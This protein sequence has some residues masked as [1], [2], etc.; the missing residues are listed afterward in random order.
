MALSG[1]D[2]SLAADAALTAGLRL[3]GNMQPLGLAGAVGLEAS[4]LVFRRLPPVPERT[5]NIPPEPRSFRVRRARSGFPGDRRVMDIERE[6][7]EVR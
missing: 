4:I 1:A 5:W 2:A 7:R 3:A 6:N